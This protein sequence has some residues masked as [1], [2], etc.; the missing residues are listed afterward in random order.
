MKLIDSHCHLHLLNLD[1]F[2]GKLSHVLA[3]GAVKNIVHYL[4][5]SVELGDYP[6]LREIA[7]QF[8]QVS[9]SVGVHPN[10]DTSVASLSVEDLTNLAIEPYCVAIGETGLDY[11]RVESFAQKS[12]QQQYFVTHI[13]AAKQTNTPLI[14]HTRQASEDTLSLLRSEN[15][16]QVGGVMHCFTETWEVAS[17][18]ID[19]G[20]YISFS[21]ILTFKNA[22]DLQEV[23]KKV[24][25][26]R[27]LIETDSPYLA[28]TPFRGQQNHPALVYRVAEMLAE[29][30]GTTFEEIANIT[31]AN[32]YEC[33]PR[34]L[35]ST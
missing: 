27:V 10:H 11:Y 3:E 24:P 23:A 6:V 21:G 26:D 18:A 33:F 31:T 4:C 2:S 34:A 1:D 29:L 15:A 20:F 16:S 25:L 14:I 35:R 13:E 5:V 9:I 22:T 32:F 30:R 19:L 17:K 12:I 28:P 7:K 8:P